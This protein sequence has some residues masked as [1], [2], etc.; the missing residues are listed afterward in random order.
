MALWSCGQPAW[1]VHN[2]TERPPPPASLSQPAPLVQ[3]AKLDRPIHHTPFAIRDR[4]QPDRFTNQRLTQKY[5]FPTP[6]NLAVRAH[7]AHRRRLRVLRRTQSAA[8]A[9][10]TRPIVP[11]RR[12]LAQRFMR[13]LLVVAATERR[14][15]PRLRPQVRRRR[16]RR[17]LPER[18][19]HPLVAA[20]LLRRARINPLRPHRKLDQPHRKPA[21]ATRAA[22]RKRRSVVT[23]K[24]L[25]QPVFAK[26]RL[27]DRAHRRRV[28]PT[29]SLATQQIAAPAVQQRERL[30]ARAIA[31]TEP[32]LEISRPNR[33]RPVT[34][35]KRRRPRRHSLAPTPRHRQPGFVEQRAQRARRRPGQ[36]RIMRHQPR[37]HFARAPARMAAPRSKCR[38]GERRRDL[39]RMPQRRPAALLQAG[40]PGRLV[41]IHPFVAG[42]P[43]HPIAA[44]QF[45]H[46]NSILPPAHNE[47]QPLVHGFGPLPRH[48]APPCRQ[49]ACYPSRRAELLPMSPG[50]T[51]READRWGRGPQTSSS[52]I[53]SRTGQ[54]PCL[55]WLAPETSQVPYLPRP[56]AATS[57]ERSTQH[58]CTGS[59]RFLC[60][61][62]F[63]SQDGST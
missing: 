33:I 40:Q 60:A 3:H 4:A 53:V 18:Q 32:A 5:P 45:R 27:Q 9:A 43:A 6:L 38:L 13:P 23:A 19:M 39:M 61:A 26:R 14:K 29:H 1:V 56:T 58:L 54:G 34:V 7:L 51:S 21:Q 62:R 50:W 11:L 47:R 57:A 49:L 48:G 15:T 55:A 44:A 17:L 46:R 42:L 37:P 30:A 16:V 41:T 59:T 36:P 12:L 25:R 24:N 52:P 31:G 2:S 63:I 20:V 35:G 10:R 8:V 22:A 28:G